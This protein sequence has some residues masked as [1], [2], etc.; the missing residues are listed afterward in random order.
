[1]ER[2]VLNSAEVRLAFSSGLVGVKV[3]TDRRKDLIRRFG[4]RTLPTDIF[5]SPDGTVLAKQV[6]STVRSVYVATLNKY[7]AT[8]DSRTMI[9]GNSNE[10]SVSGKAA[11][12]ESV[13]VQPAILTK[14]LLDRTEA[15]LGLSGFCPVSLYE[16]SEWTEGQPQFGFVVEGVRYQFGSRADLDRFQSNPVEFMPVLHGCDP[17]SLHTCRKMQSG[18]IE[19]GARFRERLYFFETQQNRDTFLRNP[20]RYARAITVRVARQ[21]EAPATVLNR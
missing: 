14:A 16:R 9:V 10:T 12:P 7:R 5:L 3:D 4:L 13:S 19:L 6:G 11:P 20:D 17:V 2:T 8:P 21:A 18:N 1:M 15:Q